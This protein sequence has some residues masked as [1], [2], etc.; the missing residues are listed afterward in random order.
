MIAL[1]PEWIG[2]VGTV[3]LSIL[4]VFQDKIR[5]WLTRPQLKLLAGIEPPYCHKTTWS[6]PNPPGTPLSRGDIETKYLPCYYFRVAISNVGN[7]AAK[8][9]EVNAI[10]LRKRRADGDYVSVSRFTPMNLLWAHEHSVYLHQLPPQMSKY[11]DIGH[12]IVPSERLKLGHDLPGIASNKCIFAFDLQAEPNMKG[13]L[14]DPGT[15]RL[16]LLIA[17]ENCQ[18]S[19][20]TIE[21]IFPGDW[22]DSQDEMFSNG[23]GIRIV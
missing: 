12:V 9:V 6:Y 1:T 15:Y 23:F 10:S 22:F 17:A 14:V 18:P 16:D 5:A 19:Q 11:C 21:L 4:A 8:E 2:A 3:L 13:H 20:Y 7:T